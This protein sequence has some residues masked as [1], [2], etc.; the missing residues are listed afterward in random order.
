MTCILAHDIGTTGDKA[1]LFGEDGSVVA[2][3]FAP[4]PTYYPHPGWCEQDPTDWWNAVV[5]ST[6]NLIEK[7]GVSVNDI[8]AVGFSGHMMGCLPVADDGTPLSRSMIHSDT[9]SAGIAE[10]VATVGVRD[11]YE[12]TGN[13][14]DSHYPAPKIAWL[15]E[16]SSDVSR[17]ARWFL[18]SKDWIAGRLTGRFGVTDFSDA[19]LY[20]VFDITER[21][22]SEEM[23]GV[24]GVD[25][26]K[27]PD[28]VASSEVIGRVTSSTARETGLPEGLPVVIG[29][30]DGACAAVG[31]GAV[32]IGDAYSYL[33]STAWVAAVTDRPV[34]DELM[35]T[36]VLCNLD[37]STYSLMGTVQAAGTA[38]EWA[39]ETLGPDIE[40][41]IRFRLLDEM[42][43]SIPAG[44][45]GL[46]F[47]PYLLGERTP[48]WDPD[49]RGVFFGLGAEHGRAHMFRAVLE[50]VAYALRSVADL[51]ES[52]GVKIESLGMIGG[53]ASSEL[54]TE[55][56][57]SVY[58][59]TLHI[60]SRPKEATSYGAAMAAGIG[61]GIFN[62]YD[63]ARRFVRIDRDVTPGCESDYTRFYEL[64][65]SLYPSLEE[66]FARL[67]E[68]R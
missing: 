39:A 63:E 26:G 44:S 52:N 34:I 14:C 22:W 27:L 17:K 43:K 46:I 30:G 67:A 38:C 53:G 65:A 68:L 1:T 15:A 56:L 45:G 41:S 54:W 4:Y 28:I 59:R 40:P 8:A 57:A 66:S 64:F 16:H 48:I 49:A 36:F 10:R 50:G 13:P 3:A 47:L 60:P 62:G 18:Q 24:W 9:R 31:A 19:S 55:I 23:C 5:T 61:V 58:G 11:I 42:A 35:R 37:P 20:G 12:T 51:I 7:S 2:S 21:R 33:G 29:G 6:R 25:E 32:S